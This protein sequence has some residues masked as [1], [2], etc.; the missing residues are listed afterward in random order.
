MLSGIAASITSVYALLLHNPNSCELLL[1]FI[2]AL[3]G[4]GLLLVTATEAVCLRRVRAEHGDLSVCAGILNR[5]LSSQSKC[6]DIF[7]GLQHHLLQKTSHVHNI[8]PIEDA[9]DAGKIVIST[10][11]AVAS[12]VQVCAGVVLT[13]YSAAENRF[14]LSAP[15]WQAI[16]GIFTL[17]LSYVYHSYCCVFFHSY[18]V[19]CVAVFCLIQAAVPWH[20]PVRSSS[21]Q[22]FSIFGA[23][24]C[25]ALLALTSFGFYCWAHRYSAPW[26]YDRSLSNL[27]NS[28]SFWNSTLVRDKSATS[29]IYRYCIVPKQAYMLCE[30]TLEFSTP[31]VWWTQEQVQSEVEIIQIVVLVLLTLNGC[32]HFLLF[33]Y[34]AFGS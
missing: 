12:L 18:F 15:H 8:S 25:S 21:R 19:T 5:T 28:Q 32:L 23:G 3:L 4:F 17:L 30:R 20:F 16:F 13:L 10:I 34:D 2:S 22:L 33:I 1:Q 29:G 24:L 7:G 31:Y 11:L 27:V 6:S 26:K 14:Q 9:R